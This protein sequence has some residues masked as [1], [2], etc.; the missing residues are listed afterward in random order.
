MLDI[1]T[2]PKFPH[3]YIFSVSVHTFASSTPGKFFLKHGPLYFS[4]EDVVKVRNV[5]MLMKD[6]IYQEIYKVKSTR[7]LAEIMGCRELI[8]GFTGLQFSARANNASLHHFSSE[9]KINGEDFFVRYVDLANKNNKIKER[10][11]DAKI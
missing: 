3:H 7:E 4:N 11:M 2:D 8:T 5:L 6:D 9:T 10:L 1:K